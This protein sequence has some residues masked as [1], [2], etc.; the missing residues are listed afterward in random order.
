MRLSVAE[1]VRTA[2][3]AVLHEHIQPPPWQTLG[4][5]EGARSLHNLFCGALHVTGTMVGDL[6]I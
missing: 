3:L 1:W 6:K 4:R 2:V 5:G